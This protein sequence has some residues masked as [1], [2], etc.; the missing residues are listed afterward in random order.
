MTIEFPDL[1]SDTKPMDSARIAR[2]PA[3]ALYDAVFALALP[4]VGPLAE[5]KNVV[6][7]STN[8][9]GVLRHAMRNVSRK[10]LR[11]VMNGNYDPVLRAINRSLDIVG[12]MNWM[13]VLRFARGERD[14]DPLVLIAGAEEAVDQEI[15][16]SRSA[17]DR[18]QG[19]FIWPDLAALARSCEAGVSHVT[20]A[21]PQFALPKSASVV[22]SMT[23]A[24]LS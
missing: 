20:I 9:A 21:M 13:R 4:T 23:R 1:N 12:A 5:R 16:K 22:V 3:G 24:I 6:L 10:S 11:A 19:I 18:T 15:R 14:I 7:A 2:H 8:H 17:N